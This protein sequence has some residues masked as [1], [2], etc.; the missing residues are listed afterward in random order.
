[1]A[2]LPEL[3]LRCLSS[4]CRMLAGIRLRLMRSKWGFVCG[5]KSTR[6]GHHAVWR[7]PS[8]CAHASSA[9]QAQHDE[10]TQPRVSRSAVRSSSSLRFDRMNGVRSEPN[11]SMRLSTVAS[12]SE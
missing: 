9:T 5:E 11:E 7:A 12:K 2:N 3:A 8:G 6:T 10:C 4:V 1:M